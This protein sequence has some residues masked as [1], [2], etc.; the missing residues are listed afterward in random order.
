MH[1]YGPVPSRRL[2]RSIGVSPIPSKT[3]SYSCVYCQLGPTTKFT[4][5]RDSFFDRED[6]LQELINRVKDSAADFITYVGDGEPTLCSYLGWLIGRTQQ[7]TDLPI[8]VITNGS[9]L[10]NKSV[11]N[12][13]QNADIVMPSIDAGDEKTFQNINRPHK[14]LDFTE[15]VQGIIKFNKKFKGNLWT[16]TMLVQG[17]NDS[18]E[19]INK[20]NGIINKIKPKKSFTMIPTR[21]PVEDVH[22][23]KPDNLLYA[24]KTISNTEAIDYIE[25]GDF[26]INNYENLAEALNEISKRHPL[27]KS[28]A[29]IIAR[30]LK[31]EKELEELISKDKFVIQKFA[32]NEYILPSKL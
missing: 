30:Q 8:A 12:E 17:Y 5:Q 10:Y 4:I 6:I 13:L 1:T 26:N 25:E 23:P 9:L 21:P 14:N 18:K 15:I 24:Q 3:C 11:Q 28:Q 2:G 27:R 20:I 19:Q 7:Y 16:E 32:S 22:P 29:Q 31:Q